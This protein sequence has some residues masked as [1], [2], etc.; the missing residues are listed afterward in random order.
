MRNLS[1]IVVPATN[2][3]SDVTGPALDCSQIY[4]V[5]FQASF[6]SNTL[7]GTFKFQASNDISNPPVNWSDVA[8]V[9]V[10]AGGVILIPKTDVCYQWI[11][12]VYTHTAGAGTV[13]MAVNS[14]GF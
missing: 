4:A 7:T 9:N 8:S 12:P 11:R 1:Q 6:S 3:G 10:A 5:S 14:Q 13:T 2:A